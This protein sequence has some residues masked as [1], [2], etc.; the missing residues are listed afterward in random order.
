[1]SSRRF[2][3]GSS[4]TRPPIPIGRPRRVPV[5]RTRDARGVLPDDLAAPDGA[6]DRR[7]QA[8]DD[9][10]VGA[11]TAELEAQVVPRPLG[12]GADRIIAVGRLVAQA[13]DDGVTPI[14]GGEGGRVGLARPHLPAPRAVEAAGLDRSIDEPAEL[15][16]QQPVGAQ[17]LELDVTGFAKVLG[18][19]TDGVVLLQRPSGPQRSKDLVV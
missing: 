7:P 15:G 8:L 4:R 11:E 2:A 13:G 10:A 5:A 3:S 16:I 6:V 17:A 1:M 14:I 19:Q 18:H 12:R 9:V